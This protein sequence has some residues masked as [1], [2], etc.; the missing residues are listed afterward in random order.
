MICFS[1]EIIQNQ[2]VTRAMLLR[3][4]ADSDEPS[5]EPLDRLP[6]L[7]SMKRDQNIGSEIYCP[8]LFEQYAVGYI[9]AADTIESNLEIDVEMVSYIH[10]FSQILAFAL[11]KNGYFEGFSRENSNF[12]TFSYQFLPILTDE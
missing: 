3:A 4:G 5:S 6:S 2:I 9:Y 7:L 8:I 12:R 1:D 10:E 11:K